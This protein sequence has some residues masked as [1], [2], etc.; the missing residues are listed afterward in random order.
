MVASAG[1]RFP[2][3]AS[4]GPPASGSPH[5]PQAPLIPRAFF[6]L[7]LSVTVGIQ[8]Y[9]VAICTKTEQELTITQKWMFW[10]FE[11][12]PNNA[13]P[14]LG[15]SWRFFYP[16]TNISM[17]PGLPPWVPAVQEDE[18]VLGANGN[19]IL[20]PKHHPS[21]GS[22]PDQPNRRASCDC[23]T[24]PCF[25]KLPYATISVSPDFLDTKWIRYQS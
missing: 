2:T 17:H 10:N 1:Q 12:R 5:F 13:Q 8:G 16:D 20:N 19:A 3:W 22:L 18:E 21:L 15:A 23:K 14:S 6:E 7:L 11:W 4:P 9:N 25:T 24:K